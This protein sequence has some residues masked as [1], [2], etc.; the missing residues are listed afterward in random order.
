MSAF[1]ILERLRAAFAVGDV[2]SDYGQER[3][4]DHA[5]RL[6]VT[7]RMRRGQLDLLDAAAK[8]IFGN[9][10]AGIVVA[11]IIR[12]EVTPVVLAV[13]LAGLAV[14]SWGL[15]ARV[16]WH[17][18]QNTSERLSLDV[19]THRLNEHAVFAAAL[20]LVWGVFI[21]CFG[22]TLSSGSL[23]IVSLIVIGCISG[24][25]SAIGPSLPVFFGF[26]LTTLTAL[27]YANF[28]QASPNGRL[29]A[30]LIAL[31]GIALVVNVLTFNRSV[32]SALRQRAKN[33]LLAD[34][35]AVAEAATEA[36]MRSKW[37][38][39]AHL[40]HE[41]RTPMN[42]VLGFSDMMRQ[43]MFGALS[44]RYLD[45]AQSIHSSGNE[46]LALIDSILEVSRARTGEMTL[47][48]SRFDP[49]IL[50]HELVREFTTAAT[51][52]GIIININIRHPGTGLYA[53]RTKIRQVL[54]NLISNALNYT[55][56]GGRITLD[57]SYANEGFCLTVTDTGVGIAADEIAF[58]QEPFVRLGDPL[59]SRANGAGLGL[60]I[61]KH[62]LE[63][64]GGSLSI[65]SRLGHGTSVTFLLPASRCVPLMGEDHNAAPELPFLRLVNRD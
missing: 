54:H 40:S 63:A 8:T 56:A 16:K 37:V 15:F 47:A 4:I 60:P 52:A 33:E 61:A 25:L 44:P 29:Y 9:F 51:E 23:V 53:D 26:F 34:S 49:V 10:F 36:A 20:G 17:K 32:L 38:S 35:L 31:Y 1:S 24:T 59:I 58:C 30:F 2:R 41:L 43:Q 65:E 5:R 57:L 12:H 7:T 3:R 45:Y 11:F 55:C 64:H 42:A 27:I 62:L 28:I 48:E 13:W 50:A 14:V 22:P 21:V 6:D 19:I 46:A 39:F 18:K